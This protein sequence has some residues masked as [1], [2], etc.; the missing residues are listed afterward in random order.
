L[1]RHSTAGPETKT[2]LVY[3]EPF[4]NQHRKF[5]YVDGPW[6]RMVFDENLRDN[7]Q[8]TFQKVGTVTIRGITYPVLEFT[9]VDEAAS[10]A[11]KPQ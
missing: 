9:R 3:D 1:Y 8:W 5:L 11:I 7:P 4:L 6:Q 10:T 2:L